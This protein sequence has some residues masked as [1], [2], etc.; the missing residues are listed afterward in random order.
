[1]KLSTFLI[2]C[3]LYSLIAVEAS[4]CNYDNENNGHSAISIT[5]NDGFYSYINNLPDENNYHHISH[6]SL[7]VGHSHSKHADCCGK[8]PKKPFL[9]E[10]LKRKNVKKTSVANS[11]KTLQVSQ[12]FTE[13]SNFSDY[14]SVLSTKKIPLHILN[15]VFLA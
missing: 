3:S 15:M 14:N 12:F 2:I 11:I 8:V 6:H 9:F 13:N 4:C 7:K 5:A 10:S 1:M